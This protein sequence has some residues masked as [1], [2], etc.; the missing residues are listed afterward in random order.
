MN[1]R[2]ATSFLALS[3]FTGAVAV[4]PAVLRAEDP[5]KAAESVDFRKLKEL[6]PA[7][8]AGMKRTACNGERNKLGEI[9]V[10][11]VTATYGGGDDEKAPKIEI[12]AIDYSGTQMAAGLAAAWS[13]AEI[14]KESDDGFEKTVKVGGNPGFFTWQKESKHGQVQ[15]LVGKRYIVSVQTDNVPSDKILKIA[16]SLPLDKIAALK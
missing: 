6:M 2:I 16:E 12:Q 9:S 7:D 11:T 13:L 5:P 3:V 4:M 10:T 1:H 15:I 14:D 8:V